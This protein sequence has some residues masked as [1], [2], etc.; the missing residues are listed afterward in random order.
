MRSHNY[1]MRAVSPAV[2]FLLAAVPAGAENWTVTRVSGMA[3]VRTSEQPQ[4]RIVPG[5]SIPSSAS[6]GTAADGRVMLER[7]QGRIVVSPG[8][9]LVSK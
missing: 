2:A 7:G 9:T 5:M 3:W 6:I 1:L 8:T 4:Q